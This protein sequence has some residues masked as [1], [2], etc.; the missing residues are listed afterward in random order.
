LAMLLQ[1]LRYGL[2]R[3]VRTPG[4]TLTAVLTLALGIGANTA[5]FSTVNAL[6]L[7][8]YPFPNLERLMLVREADPNRPGD[9][10]S[11]TAD[12]LDIRTQSRTFSDLAAFRFGNFNLGNESGTGAV[13]GYVVTPNL[14]QMI[15]AQP[16]L[17]RNL[18]SDDAQ[19]GRNLVAVISH[20]TWRERFASDSSVVGK[21]VTLNGHSTAIIG[22]MPDGFHYPLGAEIWMPLT[23]TSAD[24]VDRLSR[25]LYLLASLKD[26]ISR[27]QAEAEL[28]AFS[29]Q[30][31]Q[32]YPTTNI[33][34]SATLLPLRE[35]QYTYTAPMFLML[36]AAAGFVLLLACANLL[37]LLLAQAVSRRREIA[38][39][40]SLGADGVRL[41]QLFASETVLLAALAV[42]LAVS[43]SY[44][45]VTAIR[46]G[47]PSGMTKWIAGWSDIH[48]DARVL[49][50][51]ALLALALALVLG[52]A[53]TFRASRM[54]LSA[55][56]KDSSRSSTGSRAQHRVL[57]VLV[58]TQVVLALVLL[59]GAASTIRSFFALSKVYKGFDP[60]DLLTLEVRLPK[61]AY[62][63]ATKITSFYERALQQMQSLP[64][65]ESAA[66]AANTPASNVDNERVTFDI[67]GRNSLRASEAPAG[68][69]QVV[70][71]DFLSALRISLLQGRAFSEGD[72]RNSPRVALISETMA[73]RN[74]PNSTPLGQS[75]KLNGDNSNAVTVVGVVSDVKLNWYDPRPRPTIYLPYLQAPR[76]SLRL[77]ARISQGGHDAA[78]AIRQRLQQLDPEVALNEIHPLTSEISDSLAPIRIIGWLMLVFGALALALSTIGIYGMLSHRVA[79]RTHEFGVRIALG[80]TSDDLFRQILREA[81]KL[82]GAGLA[83]GLPVAYGLNLLAASRLFGLNGLSWPMLAAF[84][85]GTLLVALLAA[86][87]PARRAMRSDPILA[88]RY[89]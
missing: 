57:S 79:R 77:V 10:R 26:G 55:A 69:L 87:V 65:V 22:V 60:D 74:W 27:R 48:L 72:G 75:L 52:L 32:Q 49:S 68:D 80:A 5:I 78:N 43:I 84:T 20:N 15:G 30:L 3:L 61:Q 36:Q 34:R 70:S 17:G 11:A 18:S 1:D 86:W 42:S 85:V 51:A 54:D 50:F 2:R 19:E 67:P 58:I 38:V 81:L 8:P 76:A 89:E 39:R 82:A 41:A 45:S 64:Q 47:M 9:D 56:L 62:S 13:E 46:N 21:T 23:L 7:R 71:P 59:A 6:L 66:L 53:S 40:S 88:L 35:E 12:Y 33:H 16:L 63:D 24:R 29:K 37:N 14:F 83:L 44:V 31:Q 4:F 73:A 25:S 28:E